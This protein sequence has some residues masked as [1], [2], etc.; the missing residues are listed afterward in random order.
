MAVLSMSDGE[1]R[2]LEVLRDVDRGGLPVR[3]AAQLLGRSE[4]HVWRLLKAFR[5]AGAAG[6]I[7]KKR[8][9]PSNRRTAAAV[10]A[11]VLWVVRHNYAD[12]GPTLAAEKLAAEHGFSF[13]SETLRKWMIVDGLWRD[14]KQRRRVHQP[15]PRRECVGELVQ[16]DGS[17]HWWFEDRGPQC[18]LLVF[19]DDATS[20][21]MHLQFVESESTFAYF[22]AARAYLEAW[23]KPVAFYSDKHGVFRVNH[24]GALGGDGMTQFG[25]ALHA[26]NIDIICAN[27][28]PAKGRVERANK[29]LQDR[30]V[31]ELRLAGAAT[32]A[33]GNALLPAF[34][35]D[36]NARFAKAPANDKDLHRPLRA[37]DD[38]DDT[39]AWKEERTLSQALTLQYD[40]VVFILEPS[41][42]AK[43]AIG[44]RVTVV[45]YPDG[46]LAIRYRGVELAYRTFDKVRQVSQAAIVENKQ[47]GAA[48]A[49]IR[50]Q[51]LRREPE[52]RSDRA[53]R[54]RDQRNAC[55]FKS[56]EP[57]YEPGVLTPA[58]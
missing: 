52:H 37:G 11:A 2:R 41:E 25:R 44:K 27:S 22:H 16:V 43:A 10:R 9:Q 51:Q 23:G 5:S 33:E 26:L 30:L 21:L 24:P 20:R 12:F 3:A 32:L 18:T 48:L 42:Q 28:S 35:A 13:S 55:L 8:G 45:D 36:Y 31:K 49:F 6:L 47:L 46:R 4:R 57:F 15:R 54:R 1:L 53:P 7:S 50:D 40:K 56:A 19:V 58:R 14:R 39:F 34:I 17:E 38:L 29:T